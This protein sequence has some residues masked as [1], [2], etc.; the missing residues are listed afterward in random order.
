MV[1][2]VRRVGKVVVVDAVRDGWW[3]GFFIVLQ[4]EGLM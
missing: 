2:S 1:S 3:D 4:T